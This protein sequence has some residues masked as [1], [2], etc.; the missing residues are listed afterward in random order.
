MLIEINETEKEQL[1]PTE[2]NVINWLNEH[3]KCRI[4]CK[5]KMWGQSKMTNPTSW[6]YFMKS[7][8]MCFWSC[9]G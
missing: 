1:T 6:L 9:A 4:S 2:L 5:N 8:N 7:V 3:E